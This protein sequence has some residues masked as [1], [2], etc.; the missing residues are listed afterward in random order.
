M[1]IFS[2]FFSLN[3][4]AYMDRTLTL[5]GRLV[6][7]D[8]KTALIKNPQGSIQIPKTSIDFHGYQIGQNV[9]VNVDIAE[10]LD[11]NRELL[12]KNKI[13]PEK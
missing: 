5:E 6:K 8:K 7:V 3:A 13:I 4:W 11:L 9:I 1:V 2:A 10:F 12:I